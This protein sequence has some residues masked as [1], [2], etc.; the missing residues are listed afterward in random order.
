[1][2]NIEPKQNKLVPRYKKIPVDSM[3]IK[4]RHAAV[5]ANWIQRKDTNAIIP[6]DK[7]KF[8]LIYRQSRDGSDINTMRNKCNGQG[9][10]IL[11][12]KTKENTTIIGG[13]NPNGNG[14]NL[15][16]F[17]ISRVKNSGCA[18]Y[19]SYYQ[20]TALNFGNSDLVINNN[21]GTCNKSQYE[22]NILETKSFNIE[23]MEIFGFQ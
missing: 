22:S 8:T 21:S 2:S 3:I 15:K 13:Y 6:K 9:A 14:M 4:P 20:N 5:L 10:C 17:K 7:Y 12:I 23:E 11:I 1:M 19:E 18:M 16:N